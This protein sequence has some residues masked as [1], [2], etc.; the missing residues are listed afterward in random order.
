M[1]LFDAT[2][3]S[4]SQHV[5]QDPARPHGRRSRVTTSIRLD[6]RLYDLVR[7]LAYHRARTGR[8]GRMSASAL[9]EEALIAREPELRN[10]VR[11][12][13]AENREPTLAG[14]LSSALG[15]AKIR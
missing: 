8:V 7:E 10:E 15:R 14:V 9:V 3:F 13:C 1:A 11:E 6:R 5:L 4:L 2:G 12:L